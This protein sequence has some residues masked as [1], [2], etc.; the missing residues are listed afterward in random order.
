MA[1]IMDLTNPRASADS[2][3]VWEKFI[4]IPN[5]TVGVGSPNS[6]A[7]F[8]LGTLSDEDIEEISKRSLLSFWLTGSFD[9][10][11]TS[12]DSPVYLYLMPGTSATSSY[13]QSLELYPGEPRTYSF[14][15]GVL[16]RPSGISLTKRTN[17]ALGIGSSSWNSL[18]AIAAFTGVAAFQGSYL[19]NLIARFGTSTIHYKQLVITN[20]NAGIWLIAK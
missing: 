12:T 8:S 3:D 14:G 15:N 7:D 20:S 11:A 13:V 2:G 16:V 17:D 10:T 18:S 4:P 9:Y 1:T 19:K 5:V 6:Y